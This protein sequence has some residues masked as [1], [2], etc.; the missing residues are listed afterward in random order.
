MDTLI[1][2][3]S[4][5]NENLYTQQHKNEE[6][7]GWFQQQKKDLSEKKKFCFIRQFSFSLATRFCLVLEEYERLK[8]RDRAEFTHW[9][10]E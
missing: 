2:W 4:S 1:K 7:F 10:D 6:T 8:I 3:E 9:M 5:E